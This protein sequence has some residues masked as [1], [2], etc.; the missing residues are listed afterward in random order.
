MTDADDRARLGELT[1]RGYAVVESLAS[2]GKGRQLVGLFRT[3]PEHGAVLRG[4]LAGGARQRFDGLVHFRDLSRRTRIEVELTKVAE[5]GEELLA[6][7][8]AYDVPYAL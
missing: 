4:A 1:G 2:L 7:F 8:V 6:E 5:E 3:A